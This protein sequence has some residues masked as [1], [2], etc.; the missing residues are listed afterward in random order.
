MSV[1]SLSLFNPPPKHV[2]HPAATC[3]IATFG[4]DD[5]NGLDE[6]YRKAVKLDS[7][8]FSSSFDAVEA[9]L[10]RMACYELFEGPNAARP[11]KA[12]LYKLNIFG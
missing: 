3:D 11:V 4:I 5:Q 1:V 6:S 7:T 2:E 10:V 8:Q 9:G 12:E